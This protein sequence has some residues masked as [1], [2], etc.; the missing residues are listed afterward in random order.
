[1]HW[2]DATELERH[3]L[4]ADI[5]PAE[6]S[7]PTNLHVSMA[8]FNQASTAELVQELTSRNDLNRS[9]IL[10]PLLS[11]RGQY[12]WFD[13]NLSE[14]VL[15]DSGGLTEPVIYKMIYFTRSVH[16]HISPWRQIIL[17]QFRCHSPLKDKMSWVNKRTNGYADKFIR[18]PAKTRN[19]AHTSL[20]GLKTDKLSH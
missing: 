18:L 13:C 19:C 4:K 2:A 10:C 1:M 20:M 9:K 5:T 14:L 11:V 12:F 17:S 6:I 7:N 16:K 3:G 8:T 15:I